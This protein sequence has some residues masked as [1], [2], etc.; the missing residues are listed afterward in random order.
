MTLHYRL[1]CVQSRPIVSFLVFSILVDDFFLLTACL[2][3]LFPRTVGSASD[4]L[5]SVAPSQTALI[6]LVHCYCYQSLRSFF[7]VLP[8]IVKIATDFMGPECPSLCSQQFLG[9][10]AYCGYGE[11][12]LQL[13]T[14]SLS[15][16]SEC[17]TFTCTCG[18]PSGQLIPEISRPICCIK[19]VKLS[20]YTPRWRLG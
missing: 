1:L 5:A 15:Y 12:D 8:L 19:K 9:M 18:L 14:V 10:S 17:Y 20:R 7:A 11:P 16:S 4:L 13:H 6:D 2:H 3:A